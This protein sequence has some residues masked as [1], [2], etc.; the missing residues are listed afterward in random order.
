MRKALVLVGVSV[1]VVALLPALATANHHNNMSGKIVFHIEP[2]AADSEI[3]IMNEDGSGRVAL[4]NN[5]ATDERPAWSP[6]GRQIAFVSDRNG[7]RSLW[8][9]DEDGSNQ[10]LLAALPAPGDM[11]QIDWSPDGTTIAAQV[12]SKGPEPVGSDNEIYLIDVATGGSTQITS[13]SI[14]DG[15]PRFSPDGSK[16]LIE[17]MV[18]M[19]HFE[20]FVIDADGSNPVNLTQS[21]GS[22]DFSPSWS[23]DGKYV[24]FASDREGPYDLWRMDADGSNPVQLTFT[25]GFDD[26]TDWSKDG[27]QIIYTT[28][29]VDGFD[30]GIMNADGS[31]RTLLTENPID[32]FAPRWQPLYTCQGSRATIVGT[33]GSDDITGTAGRD[34]IVGLAG[35]DVIDAKAGD[36]AVCGGPG[37]DDMMGGLGND[38]LNGQAGLD[39]V[40]YKTSAAK[41]T[42][43]LAAGTSS[44]GHGTDTISFVEHIKGSIHNDTLIGTNGRNRII[45]RNGHDILR[46]KAGDDVLNGGYGKDTASYIDAP[47]GVNVDLVAGTATGDGSDGLYGVEHLTGSNH[48]DVLRGSTMINRIIGGNGDDVLW[49]NAGNDTLNGKA[50]DDRLYGQGGNDWLY[51]YTGVDTADGGPGTDDLCRAESMVNCE[52]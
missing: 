34:V 43:N 10:T 51:G 44:G 42:V 4:T 41:V 46:G 40:D 28:S 52:K 20:V 47:S 18:D 27:K 24:T 11:A 25:D 37:H 50:G 3:Y 16:L 5:T 35:N 1:L 19:D 33:G 48:N 22:W 26:K 32:E 38:F 15:Q 8:I 13:N 21:P 6:D 49:G 2:D 36:D 39:W 12:G 45:G 23:P 7:T 30:I 9:M 14:F 29:E 17:R 31:N